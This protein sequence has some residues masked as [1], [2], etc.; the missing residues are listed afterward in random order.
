MRVYS[1]AQ[2][3]KI[4]SKRASIWGSNLKYWQETKSTNNA[5]TTL[6][7]KILKET[8]TLTHFKGTKKKSS[9]KKRLKNY[10][11]L[12]YLSQRRRK[13]PSSP[14]QWCNFILCSSSIKAQVVRYISMIKM[15]G[16]LS[17]K[18]C[19]VCKDSIVSLISMLSS[20]LYMPKMEST[21]FGLPKTESQVSTLP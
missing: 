6:I 18:D 9:I 2:T 16:N 11:N 8:N 21:K 19:L 10:H 1:L 15:I 5:K 12:L 7:L 17:F 20:S 3:R 4:R 13:N 14:W